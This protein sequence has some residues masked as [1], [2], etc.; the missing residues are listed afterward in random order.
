MEKTVRFGIVGCGLIS[1]FHARAIAAVP[2]AALAGAWDVRPEAAQAFAGEFGGSAFDTFERMLESG[3]VDAVSICTPS[4]LHGR[5]AIQALKAG[6]HVLVEKPMAL[7]LEEADE[8]IG[9][10]GRMGVKLSVVSQLRFSEGIAAAKRAI[11]ENALGKLIC[12]DIFMKYHRSPEYYLSGLWRGTKAMDGGGALMNQGIHGVDLL[13]YLC[14]PVRQVCA[15]SR[16]LVHPIEVEDTIC[17]VLEY[18][19]GALGL[20]QAT[21]SV[22]PGFPRRME[23]SGDRGSLVIEEDR[24]QSASLEDGL[25][26]PLGEARAY[27]A[28][29]GAIDCAGH[30]RQVEDFVRAI[31]TG[32]RPLVDGREGRRALELILSAYRSSEL[33]KPVIIGEE[34]V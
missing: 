20:L 11:A 18:E 5:Q 9:L 32:G 25:S 10:A 17:A 28:D 27:S 8:A 3:A 26:L 33:G 21:T 29:P 2:G 23:L 34:S 15:L 19:S 31:N 12:G 1:K 22:K 13:L 14:G 16:T 24:I 30:A 7:S 4:G 6:K